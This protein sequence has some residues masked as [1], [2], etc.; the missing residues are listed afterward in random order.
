MAIGRMGG[1]ALNER[2]RAREGTMSRRT[3]RAIFG[4]AAAGAI[5]ATLGLTAAGPADAATWPAPVAHG[6]NGPTH[7]AYANNSAGYDHYSGYDTGANNNW[8][9]RYVATTV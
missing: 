9:F 6:N 3:T 4:A 8:L 2:R 5:I 1:R 7:V